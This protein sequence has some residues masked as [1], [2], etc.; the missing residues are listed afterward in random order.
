MLETSSAPLVSLDE[1][2]NNAEFATGSSVSI[3]ASASDSD[4]SVTRVEF[5]EGTTKLGEDLTAPYTFIWNNVAEG[6]YSLNA[7]ATDN[8]NGVTT[9]ESIAISVTNSIGNTATGGVEDLYSGIPRFFSPNDDGTGDYWE[10]TQPEL[11]ANSLLTIFNRSGQQ[12]FEALSYNNTW[13][14]KQTA[15]HCRLVIITTS[16]KCLTSRIS[17]AL[18]ESFDKTNHITLLHSKADILRGKKIIQKCEPVI[19]IEALIPPNRQC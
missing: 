4:G 1:P 15:N 11:F 19:K 18:F 9:S 6:T 3:T 7:I 17:G 14:G 12:I 8:E 13:D 5:F 10:W 16:L 2:L